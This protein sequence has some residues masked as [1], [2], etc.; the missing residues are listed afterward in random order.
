MKPH[1]TFLQSAQLYIE[2]SNLILAT[3]PLQE[4]IQDRHRELV[5]LIGF[6]NSPFAKELIRNLKDEIFSRKIEIQGL[7]FRARKLV[8]QA[9]YIR[10]AQE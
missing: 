4:Q 5:T 2:A 3:L 6:E 10:F 1:T 9:R 8:K 7:Q